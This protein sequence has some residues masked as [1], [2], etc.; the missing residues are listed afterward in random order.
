M[1]ARDDLAALLEERQDGDLDRR[2]LAMEAEHHPLLAAHLLLPI[3]V[4]QE[5]EERA[6]DAGGRLD[7]VRHDLLLA[8]LVEPRERLAAEL[9]VLLQVEIGPVG[10]AHELAPTHREL[11]QDV[12]RPLR[13]MRELVSRVLVQPHVVGREPVRREPRLTRLDPLVVRVLVSRTTLDGIVGIDEVFDLHLLE[14][15]RPKDE[16]TRRDLVAER[17]ADLRDPERQLSARRLQDIVEVHEDALRRLGTQV[18]HRCVF[19]DRSHER[20]EHEV[21]LTGRGELALAAFGTQRA[22]RS[23]ALACLAGGNLEPVSLRGLA[24]VHPRLP[25][26]LIGPKAPLALTT[27]HH[28]IGEVVDVAARLPHRGVHQDGRIE[29]DHVGAALHEVAPP[30]PLDVVSQLDPERTVVPARAGAP[31]DLT[32]LENESAALGQRDDDIHVHRLASSAIS[33]RIATFSRRTSRRNFVARGG[34]PI[35]RVR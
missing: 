15:S 14:F 21:E 16:V 23:T 9:R 22:A 5:G 31:V 12:D 26:H 18:G 8:V 24:V 2:E 27:V 33:V 4:E 25:V 13:V 20:F 11:V 3:G 17:F 6:V 32:R 7:H 35:S 1:A 34:W 10:D 29:P 19:F 30:D 28:R